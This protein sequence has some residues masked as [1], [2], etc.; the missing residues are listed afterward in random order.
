MEEKSSKLI[1]MFL[2]RTT[3]CHCPRWGQWR[4]WDADGEDSK[5]SLGYDELES[6]RFLRVR[7]FSAF[8]LLPGRYYEQCSTVQINICLIHEYTKQ[9]LLEL[10]CV[11]GSRQ[12]F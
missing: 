4:R 1:S 10:S 3:V 7:I 12:P 11:K 2:G 6:A 9:K 5:F 8:L